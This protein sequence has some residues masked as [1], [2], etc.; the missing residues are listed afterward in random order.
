LS[1]Y[2]L[3]L[4]EGIQ[5]NNGGYVDLSSYNLPLPEGIQFNNGGGV[6]LSS[7]NLPLPE[8]IQFN[9]G[10]DVDLSSYNLPLPE[11][12]QFNNGGYV[13]LRSYNLPLPEGIQFNNGGYVNLSSYNSPLPEGIQFNNGGGVD[14]RSEQ[15]QISTSYIKRF[16]IKETDGKVIIYKRVSEDYKTQEGTPNETLWL[17]GTTVEHPAWNPNQTECGEGKFHACAQPFWCDVFRDE[18]TDK[19]IAIEVEEKDLYE[20]AKNPSYPQKIGFRKGKVISEVKR[21]N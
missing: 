17:I 13:D 19:Y 15:I 14:L 21:I 9:N 8:G 20:W 1:S 6:Y 5:F 7:Y 3:P 4:P 18:K 10:G 12:I 2:N 16:K 11:G